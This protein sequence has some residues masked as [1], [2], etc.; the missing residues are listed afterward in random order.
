MTRWSDLTDAERYPL[1]ERAAELLRG[2]Y[3]C[4]RAWTAWRVGTMSE[5]DFGAACEDA[6]VVDNI[7]EGLYTASSPALD[8]ATARAEAAEQRAEAAEAR[9]AQAEVAGYRRAIDEACALLDEEQLSAW[10]TSVSPWLDGFA[11][12]VRHAMFE[13]RALAPVEPVSPAD[14]LPGGA[15]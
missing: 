7:A 9:A 11:D 2:L 1:Q 12:G 10:A 3:F 13:V 5:G 14:G 4:R 8:A 6:E 15:A